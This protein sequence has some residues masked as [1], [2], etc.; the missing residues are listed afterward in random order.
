MSRKHERM[1]RK[2]Q[3]SKTRRGTQVR[4][5]S[6]ATPPPK[7]PVEHKS[8]YRDVW[9]AA[10]IVVIVIGI[11]IAL[12]HFTVRQ[13]AQ[14]R[15]A[16]WPPA[17][18]PAAVP[19]S[20]PTLAQAVTPTAQKEESVNAMSWPNPPA[21]EIDPNKTYQALI[22]T[23]KGD[24]LIDLFAKEAPLTVNSFAFLARQGFYDGVSFHR[25][26]PGFMAQTGDPTGTGSGGPGYSFADEF[27]PTLR[28]DSEGVVSM[29]NA[30]P[31]TNG[32][33]FFITF[34]ATPHLDDA[35]TVFG[36]VVRGM[37]AVRAL[38]PRDPSRN[39]FAPRGDRI[40][41]VEIIEK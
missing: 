19:V 32:S 34:V 20:E 31:N 36:R 39:P 6:H 25:V 38:T 8:S 27:V 33:Q 23:E 3:L 17:V 18:T 13:P 41:T 2:R 28:H 29:A 9:I 7:A 21:M 37:D 16:A 5:V 14:R 22:K 4:H 11:L 26:L 30:G 10:G 12:Y 35:H 40:V 1:Q 24:V 15:D